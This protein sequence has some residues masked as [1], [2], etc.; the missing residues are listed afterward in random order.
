MSSPEVGA[1]ARNASELMR[2][3]YSARDLLAN[4][5]AF[6]RMQQLVQTKLP[7]LPLASS[8][9]SEDLRPAQLLLSPKGELV[10]IHLSNSEQVEKRLTSGKLPAQLWEDIYYSVKRRRE[11]APARGNPDRWRHLTFVRGPEDINLISAC[12]SRDGQYIYAGDS[13]GGVHVYYRPNMLDRNIMFKYLYGRRAQVSEEYEPI[14]DLHCEYGNEFIVIVTPTQLLRY[15]TQEEAYTPQ[16]TSAVWSLEK[17]KYSDNHG[18]WQL[19][20]ET[21][22]LLGFTY[23]R[24]TLALTI[25]HADAG[26]LLT[27][28]TIW[29]IYLGNN[30]NVDPSDRM[31]WARDTAFYEPKDADLSWYAVGL[32]EG[33][34]TSE[35]FAPVGQRRVIGK[36]TDAGG[37][38]LVDLECYNYYHSFSAYNRPELGLGA[39]GVI[40]CEVKETDPISAV[41]QFTLELANIILVPGNLPEVSVAINPSQSTKQLPV[42]SIALDLVH[43]PSDGEHNSSATYTFIGMS[44]LPALQGKATSILRSNHFDLIRTLQFA[45]GGLY[46]NSEYEYRS[47]PVQI[48]GGSDVESRRRFLVFSGRS[49]QGLFRPASQRITAAEANAIVELTKIDPELRMKVQ[50]GVHRWDMTYRFFVTMFPPSGADAAFQNQE[51]VDEGFVGNGL[52]YAAYLPKV[53]QAPGC[54]AFANYPIMWAESI[55]VVLPGLFSFMYNCYQQPLGYTFNTRPIP[56][57]EIGLRTRPP[58]DDIEFST[59]I[60]VRLVHSVTFMTEDDINFNSFWPIEPGSTVDIWTQTRPLPLGRSYRVRVRH[61]DAPVHWKVVILPFEV[62]AMSD[63]ARITDHLQLLANDQEA[64]TSLSNCRLADRSMDGG[65]STATYRYEHVLT[66]TTNDQWSDVPV[67][68]HCT[69]PRGGLSLLAWPSETD[70]TFVPTVLNFPGVG[71]SAEIPGPWYNSLSPA[72]VSEADYDKQRGEETWIAELPPAMPDEISLSTGRISLLAATKRSALFPQPEMTV[73]DWRDLDS[74]RTFV[75][76]ETVPNPDETHVVNSPRGG[77]VVRFQLDGELRSVD[78]LDSIHFTISPSRRTRN[79]SI[80]DNLSERCVMVPFKSM[81]NATVSLEYETLEEYEGTKPTDGFSFWRYPA[82]TLNS[83]HPEYPEYSYADY[84][85]N[86]QPISDMHEQGFLADGPKTMYLAVR[87]GFDIAHGYVRARVVRGAKPMAEGGVPGTLPQDSEVL[88]SVVYKFAVA[89]DYIIEAADA[90]DEDGKPMLML[91]GEYRPPTLPLRNVVPPNGVRELT[92]RRGGNRPAAMNRVGRYVVTARNH[93][94]AACVL[95]PT[96]TELN[97]LL[98]EHATSTDAAAGLSYIG[99]FGKLHGWAGALTKFP[100]ASIVIEHYNDVMGDDFVGTFAVHCESLNPD[101]TDRPYFV[102]LEVA[103]LSYSDEGDHESVKDTVSETIAPYLFYEMPVLFGVVPSKQLQFGDGNVEEKFESGEVLIRPSYNGRIQ[104]VFPLQLNMPLSAIPQA[105]KYY[106][107]H[108]VA[109]QSAAM[110]DNKCIGKI[111]QGMTGIVLAEGS[112]DTV[113]ASIPLDGSSL[114]ALSCKTPTSVGQSYLFTFTVMSQSGQMGL[115]QYPELNLLD[116]TP[117]Q[118]RVS[119]NV[120]IVHSDGQPLVSTI[121]VETPILLYL[122]KLLILPSEVGQKTTSR[123]EVVSTGAG[124]CGLGPVEEFDPNNLQSNILL[125]FSNPASEDE[126]PFSASAVYLYCKSLVTDGSI[127]LRAPSAGR[128]PLSTPAIST[129]GVLRLFVIDPSTQERSNNLPAFVYVDDPPVQLGLSIIPPFEENRVVTIELDNAGTQCSIIYGGGQSGGGGGSGGGIASAIIPVEPD[130]TT[131]IPVPAH[132]AEITNLV[133]ECTQLGQFG[134]QLKIT[135]TD[136]VYLTMFTTEV[137]PAAHVS[138]MIVNGD[139]QEPLPARWVYGHV[140][141]IRATVSTAPSS[142]TSLLIALSTDIGGCSLLDWSSYNL[143][144]VPEAITASLTIGPSSTE[145]DFIFTCTSAVPMGPAIAVT[146]VTGSTYAETIP[147][148]P[149][150]GRVYIVSSSNPESILDPSESPIVLGT[151]DGYQLK[152]KVEP[153]PS[154]DTT[155]TVSVPTHFNEENYGKCGLLEIDTATGLP[156]SLTMHSTLTVTVAAGDTLS[157][158]MVRVVCQ[159]LISVPVASSPYVRVGPT[160]EYDNVYETVQSTGLFTRADMEVLPTAGTFNVY[161]PLTVNVN[162]GPVAAESQLLFEWIDPEAK[163]GVCGFTDTPV[164]P[165]Y[166]SLSV[167]LQNPTS[168]PRA[169]VAIPV[170]IGQSASP[171]VYLH[172]WV[173][174]EDAVVYYRVSRLTDAATL[175]SPI[176]T[177]TQ[178]VT[179]FQVRTDDNVP[180]ES[181]I[182]ILVNTLTTMRVFTPLLSLNTELQ[183]SLSINNNAAAG[184]VFASGI[185]EPKT[186][187]VLVVSIPTASEYGTFT[188]TCPKPTASYPRVVLSPNGIIDGFTPTTSPSFFVATISCP[189]LDLPEN[190]F[191]ITYSDGGFG[192]RGYNSVATTTCNPGYRIENPTPQRTCTPSGWSGTAI[193]CIPIDCGDYPS[194]DN[195]I[196]VEY[197]DGAPRGAGARVRVTCQDGFVVTSGPPPQASRTITCLESGMWE[198]SVSCNPI[199]CM[200]P[201]IIPDADMNNV[202]ISNE[203]PYGVGYFGSTATYQCLTGFQ[204]SQPNTHHAVCT[205]SGWQFVGERVSCIAT[206]CAPLSA[207]AQGSVSYGEASPVNG[208]YSAG[209]QATYTCDSGYQ[210]DPPEAAVRTCSMNDQ[211]GVALWDGIA[212]ICAPVVCPILDPIPNAEEAIYSDITSGAQPHY[213]SKVHITCK[214]GFVIQGD[215]DRECQANGQ[216]SGPAPS[217]QARSCGDIVPENADPSALVAS[218]DNGFY[219]AKLYTSKATFS[220]H[221]G[222]DLV[223]SGSFTRTCNENG[224]WSPSQLEEAYPECIPHDCGE[225]EIIANVEETVYEAGNYGNTKFGAKV[226]Y[227]CKTNYNLPEGHSGVRECTADGWSGTSPTCTAYDCGQVPLPVGA[228]VP[229]YQDNGYGETSFNA[230][231]T[232]QCAPGFTM[233]SGAATGAECTESGWTN[234]HPVCEDINECEANPTRCETE[235]GLGS[236]CINTRGSYICTPIMMLA[237]LAVSGTQKPIPHSYSLGESYNAATRTLTLVDTDGGEQITASVH[238]GTQLVNP[239]IREIRYVAESDVEDP[240]GKGFL[241]EIKAQTVNGP[242]TRS[243]RCAIS[244][245]VGARL[246]MLHK[247]C[248]LEAGAVAEECSWTQFVPEAIGTLTIRYAPPVFVPSTLQSLTFPEPGSGTTSLVGKSS[249]G[250]LVQMTVTN[251]LPGASSLIRATYGPDGDEEKY[252]CVVDPMTTARSL[253]CQ[254]E[255]NVEGL[256]LKF[257]INA[258]GQTAISTDVFSYP[259]VPQIY[260]VSGC[261]PSLSVVNGTENCPTQGGTPLSIEGYGFLAPV[262]VYINGEECVLQQRTDTSILC[263]LP[264]SVGTQLPIVVTAASQYQESAP[265]LSYAAPAITSITSEDCTPTAD[266]KI[267]YNCPREGNVTLT[268][269]GSNF[270]AADATV[271]I[272]GSSCTNVVHDLATPHSKLRCTLPPGRQTARE[273]SVA[274]KYGESTPVGNSVL[275][276]YKQCPAG[277]RDVGIECEVCPAGKYSPSEAQP[278]CRDCP[279]GMFNSEPGQNGC[280]I[281]GLGKFSTTGA[282]NCTACAKG[283]YAAMGAPDCTTCP[284]RT[285]AAKKETSICEPCPEYMD[286]DVDGAGCHCQAGYM[287]NANGKCVPCLP[288]GDCSVSGTTIYN[289][290]PLPNYFQEVSPNTEPARRLQ[291]ALAYYVDL[292]RAFASGVFVEEFVR[293]LFDDSSIPRSQV[294]YVGITP[295]SIVVPEDAPI[296]AAYIARFGAD[297]VTGAS[298]SNEEDLSNQGITNQTQPSDSQSHRQVQVSYIPRHSDI[299]EL[300]KKLGLRAAEGW[301]GPSSIKPT[302][303]SSPFESA[304]NTNAHEQHVEPLVDGPGTNGTSLVMVTLQGVELTFDVYPVGTDPVAAIGG[305]GMVSQVPTTEIIAAIIQLF[306]TEGTNAWEQYGQL[307]GSVVQAPGFVQ[308]QVTGFVPCLNS[309]CLGSECAPGYEGAMCTKCSY[310]YGKINTFKCEKC[311]DE[312]GRWTVIIMS[313][314][315]AVAVCAVI[316]VLTIRESIRSRNIPSQYQAVSLSTTLRIVVCAIQVMA[317]ASRFDFVW[318][319]ALG[320]LLQYAD[321]SANVGMAAITVDCFLDR[322]PLVSP[323]F[324]SC[325]GALVMPAVTMLLPLIPVGIVYLIRR[326]KHTSIIQQL[327]EQRSPQGIRYMDFIVDESNTQQIRARIRRERQQAR[328]AY[329]RKLVDK[330]LKEEEQALAHWHRSVVSSASSKAKQQHIPEDAKLQGHDEVMIANLMLATSAVQDTATSAGK[331]GNE[332]QVD[333]TDAFEHLPLGPG[334]VPPSPPEPESLAEGRDG[335]DGDGISR[336]DADEGP[337]FDGQNI[338][339][340]RD[341]HDSIEMMPLRSTDD[342]TNPDFPADGAKRGAPRR[343]ARKRSQPQAL[344]T[345][346]ALDAETFREL[347]QFIAI[348]QKSERTLREQPRLFFWCYICCAVIPLYLLHPNIARMFFQMIACKNLN[349]EYVVLM[350]M[351]LSCYGKTHLLYV[352][353]IGIPLCVLWVIGIPLTFFKYLKSQSALITAKHIDLTPE[354]LDERRHIEIGFSVLLRGYKPELWYWFLS[355][356][357]RKVLYILISIFFPGQAN[358]QLLLAALVAFTAVFLH[359]AFRPLHNYIHDSLEFASL[360]GTFF[361]FFLANFYTLKDDSFTADNDT[362]TGLLLTIIIGFLLFCC[363]LLYWTHKHNLIARELRAA[364]RLAYRKNRSPLPAIEEFE[365]RQREK[366]EA[367]VQQRLERIR[368]R[369]EERTRKRNAIAAKSPHLAL[370][371]KKW[372]KEDREAEEELMQ[373]DKQERA[374]LASRD[375]KVFLTETGTPAVTADIEFDDEDEADEEHYAKQEELLVQLQQIR[376]KR[377]AI[378][379]T[380]QRRTESRFLEL[381]RSSG[382]SI[383]SAE[384]LKTKAAKAAQLAGLDLLGGQ[385][386]T[387]TTPGGPSN[388]RG[389]LAL[390]D[391]S[392]VPQ[393]DT[394]S[395]AGRRGSL[396]MAAV[397]RRSS[398]DVAMYMGGGTEDIRKL[399]KERRAAVRAAS[400]PSKAGSQE[401]NLPEELEGLD[402]G[403]DSTPVFFASTPE[404]A[405]DRERRRDYP[406]VPTSSI[407]TKLG[408]QLYFDETGTVRLLPPGRTR[409][410]LIIEESSPTG[411]LGGPYLPPVIVKDDGDQENEQDS[412]TQAQVQQSVAT[413]FAVSKPVGVRRLSVKDIPIE[414]IVEPAP[415]YGA[416][417]L[418]AKKLREKEEQLEESPEDPEELLRLRLERLSRAEA[419]ERVQ[420]LNYLGLNPAAALGYDVPAQSLVLDLEQGDEHAQ[421]EDATT[422]TKPMSKAVRAMSSLKRATTVDVDAEDAEDEEELHEDEA[423][424]NF[425]MRVTDSLPDSA[426][427]STTASERDFTTHGD[428]EARNSTGD[429]GQP[430]SPTTTSRHRRASGGPGL[431]GFRRVLGRTAAEALKQ[432]NAENLDVAIREQME[433]SPEFAALVERKIQEELQRQR[434][435]QAE[436]QAELRRQLE[437]E[438]KLNEVDRA[439]REAQLP[440]RPPDAEMSER[441]KAK[442]KPKSKSS[443]KSAETNASNTSE[444]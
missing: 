43:L 95:A 277:T 287:M 208:L 53:I 80:K 76:D 272:G 276:S 260:S 131:E 7:D 388:R 88:A 237:T 192:I 66:F 117:L 174:P 313:C 169:S 242:T 279:A 370:L 128:Y 159:E 299:A 33:D 387:Q 195:A 230:A 318:P 207:P 47:Q 290:K 200:S 19:E 133:L 170:D 257:K 112:G 136:P 227:T 305:N 323:F 289:I 362:I 183:V 386:P 240:D 282:T 94:L 401:H 418:K 380:L 91:A 441:G 57:F 96:A 213:G 17:L 357:L 182:P 321:S 173:T 306:M 48:T 12:A 120:E 273:V 189:L 138:F 322:D 6:A 315:Y 46:I 210:V 381:L 270:G 126:R 107:M 347:N 92:I 142:S 275:L 20:M 51:E 211:Y 151:D 168:H 116:A 149:V 444:Q 60:L 121:P 234:S 93:A 350:D 404:T 114:F 262:G 155:F 261:Q 405:V 167:D 333:Y 394:K 111:T 393:D 395:N 23:P 141:R 406:E 106:D 346:D 245:G 361:I 54:S 176:E 223:G 263:T 110:A 325:I 79:P 29:D 241:C 353:A 231:V 429:T 186:S 83:S 338:T 243:I 342:D 434:E 82:A 267:I 30:A 303:L 132:T 249:I 219:G 161:T 9:I 259:V 268:I 250:E 297:K 239:P 203:Q 196:N 364:I 78:E 3:L 193:S 443:V 204:I 358:V 373:L 205:Q 329:E 341:G 422:V 164:R 425:P 437:E 302:E 291:I 298:E 415:K 391:V 376:K 392:K 154:A 327:N 369:Q 304:F 256:Y 81:Y 377:E 421:D 274:Q 40:R 311:L 77:F 102:Y 248:Y 87:C 143:G 157:T 58:V 399:E 235:V 337:D 314:L 64:A 417:S 10:V 31:E 134:T 271:L 34:K 104:Y 335:D 360:I 379:K 412:T 352:L 238:V 152:V 309:A 150:A 61:G 156:T 402:L 125:Q 177:S 194:V 185:A 180:Y 147:A 252:E 85:E 44:I 359:S 198:T 371:H 293:A 86:F 330:N 414:R 251:I 163:G 137:K 336:E 288:G 423:L 127:T 411:Y 72:S 65:E 179:F 255:S 233:P 328:E 184:C 226:T 427:F 158:E 68:V 312:S 356:M 160:P 103:G 98:T 354:Q 439:L 278:D 21:D 301:F 27:P 345:V 365:R 343:H 222:F 113:T 320:V 396:D 403:E 71:V 228:G 398:I 232:F 191:S 440:V 212:P 432:R 215:S 400:D 175:T 75:N 218:Y 296:V 428:G 348:Y 146:T 220:C 316:S 355:E 368:K 407:A 14:L 294:S 372:E 178:I 70:E 140:Y 390:L 217:C 97:D 332:K 45:H 13:V 236:Q 145:A 62:R 378:K 119:H 300:S 28:G 105:D 389:S 351:S 442:S 122:R 41:T 317:I 431:G 281:C 430:R 84:F 1:Y 101:V 49:A 59:R 269:T 135:T 384:V 63:I 190:A 67:Y 162:V 375:L 363:V 201:P 26:L 24:G 165:P 367:V 285:Y 344:A 284:T 2:E 11:S 340:N 52:T 438:A 55:E 22:Q 15:E 292:D 366:D 331:R 4:R 129:R 74:A 100:D 171:P 153:A 56:Y 266:P 36:F 144:E 187:G 229:I 264:S 39:H 244:P 37:T 35:G 181:T 349:N 308:F 433:A 124:D 397:A 8:F 148:K 18:T 225:V 115:D 123:I 426:I 32:A 209:T 254:M 324:F 221:E 436:I 383:A 214:V 385:P 224:E 247:F 374:L 206:N 382:A 50:R 202:Q 188:I 73:Q 265:L 25:T 90:V 42:T 435:W 216:W 424:T 419:R 307:L 139:S 319:G 109:I 410:D 246:V 118:V 286:S 89:S 108:T 5:I 199:H 16:L 197:L 416:S 166:Q 258:G 409:A 283:K 253:V 326:H 295:R 334:E 310:G 413:H 130:Q 280:Q 420:H 38:D 69:R 339:K 172:C 408:H 99:K